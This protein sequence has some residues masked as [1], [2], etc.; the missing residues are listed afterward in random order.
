MCRHEFRNLVKRHRT[1][2]HIIFVGAPACTF[3]VDIITVQRDCD[4]GLF[5]GFA[6]ALTHDEIAGMVVEHGIEGIIGFGR[7]IFRMRMIH[8]HTAAIDCNH[9]G[10]VEL[11]S[12]RQQ[13]RMRGC[14]FQ[15]GAAGVVDRILLPIVPANMLGLFVRRGTDHIER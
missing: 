14:T 5:A 3:A 10:D 8:I 1:Q 12:V 15:P 13:I 4:T 9:I 6:R 11:R 2:H 7:G